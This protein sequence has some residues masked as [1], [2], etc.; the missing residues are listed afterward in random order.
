[1]DDNGFVI[2]EEITVYSYPATQAAEA[3]KTAVKNYVVSRSVQGDLLT[4]TLDAD[5]YYIGK[6]RDSVRCPR[7]Y[8]SY[9]V[10][11]PKFV[12]SCEEAGKNYKTTA[13][14]AKL[15]TKYKVVC[16]EDVLGKTKTV[17]PSLSLSCSYLGVI[18]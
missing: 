14:S 13:A 17:T 6:E 2:T 3:K 7:Y 1:M 11:Q 9:K 18:G 12:K 16:I 15:K 4:I 8:S 10:H 5:F